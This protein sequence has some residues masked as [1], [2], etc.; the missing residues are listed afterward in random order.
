MAPFN[1][2]TISVTRAHH[3]TLHRLQHDSETLSSVATFAV[4][5][6]GAVEDVKDKF[7]LLL[8]LSGLTCTDENVAQK[9]C[10]FE[11]CHARRVAMVMPDTS[12]RG[13][14]A[15]DGADAR[16]ARVGGGRGLALPLSAARV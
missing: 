2:K 16:A 3:G 10:A 7:P 1:L 15:A 13:D 12:P 11:H 5:V 8:Y 6:P 9:G 4:F 14:D